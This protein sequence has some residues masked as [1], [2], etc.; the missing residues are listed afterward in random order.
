MPDTSE[1]DTPLTGTPPAPSVWWEQSSD[2]A[3]L[4]PSEHTY[5]VSNG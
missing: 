3:P 2:R 4:L 5:V 1:W